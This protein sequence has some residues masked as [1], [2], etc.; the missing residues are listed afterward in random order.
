MLEPAHLCLRIYCIVEKQEMLI[1]A[2]YAIAEL[3]PANQLSAERIVP[4]VMDYT[5]APYVAS[6]VAAA[7]LQSGTPGLTG[8]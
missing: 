8:E 1:A 5:V 6:A 4:S 7:A 3:M 2:A